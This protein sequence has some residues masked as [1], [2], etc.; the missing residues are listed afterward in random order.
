MRS[1]FFEKLLRCQLFAVFSVKRYT[2]IF[3]VV[4]SEVFSA[5]LLYL[6]CAAYNTP[7]F[8]LTKAR[9]TFSSLCHTLRIKIASDSFTLNA[10]FL[11]S[12]AET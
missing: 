6:I 8:V 4:L 3:F 2:S 12:Y 11:F 9:D 10:L 5:N 7:D 1:H